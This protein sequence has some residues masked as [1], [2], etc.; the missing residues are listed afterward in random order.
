[1]FKQCAQLPAEHCVAGVQAVK[2]CRNLTARYCVA[3]GQSV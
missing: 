2:W 1:M 3:G